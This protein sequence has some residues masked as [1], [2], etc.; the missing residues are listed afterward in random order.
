MRLGMRWRRD[1]AIR[2]FGA[3]RH[4]AFRPASPFRRFVALTLAAATLGTAAA[5]G[6]QAG[7]FFYFFGAHPKQTVQAKFK[8][9]PGPLLILFD[10]SPAVDLPPE[11]RDLVVR[12]LI[13]EFKKTAINDK[14]VPPARL[15]ELR[16]THRDVTEKGTPR[17][18]REM[19]RLVDAEQVLWIYPKEFVMADAPERA[20]EPAKVSVVLKVIDAETT[21]RGKVRLWPV[22]EE[23]ELVSAQIEARDVRSAQSADEL[24]RTI[25]QQLAV[26]ISRLF[27]DY[28]AADEK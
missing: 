22:S 12:A 25:A 11:M 24:E 13:D 20:M 15:N 19:G 2:Q 1:A 16:Q 4:A 7:A 23:G 17:G 14:V 6:P 26:E 3:L 21:E 10:D 27:R 8:L 28:D 5:C 9:T 18:I